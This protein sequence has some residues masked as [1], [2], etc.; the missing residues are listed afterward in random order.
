MSRI[1]RFAILGAGCLVAIGCA[2][3]LSHSDPR[4]EGAT[5]ASV[6]VGGFARDVAS[7]RRVGPGALF[8]PS[9]RG[10]LAGRR[11][12]IDGMSC[13]ASTPVVSTTHLEVFAEDHVVVIPAGIGVAPPLR[14][15][16]AYV[17]DGSCS[18]PLSTLEPT[19]LV[20]LGPGPTRTLGEFFDV[21]GQ[22][23][24][25][26]VLAG[27]RAPRG[28][29]VALYINGLAWRGDPAGAPLLPHAQLTI[30]VGPRVPPHVHY[31]FPSL[32]LA[33]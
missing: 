13:R 21:W 20:L 4:D 30:E 5:S 29:H 12:N 19:G 6:P 32:P 16:G 1:P 24:R 22:P 23:L 28:G 17:R 25:A 8:R 33:R 26:N 3:P 11:A 7:S 31:I 14:R 18:Y 15:E 27:F 9:P 2:A 10:A